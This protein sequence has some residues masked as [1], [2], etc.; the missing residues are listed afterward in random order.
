MIRSKNAGKLLR[1][2]VVGVGRG[3]SFARGM[4][5]KIGMKLVALCDTWKERLK[6]VGR[7]Y[8]VATYASYEKFLEHEMDAVILANYFHQHAPF[9][10]QALRA[11]CHVMSETTAAKT[12][13][14]C[15]A[16]CREVE[17]SGRIYMFAENYPYMLAVQEMRRL[18]QAGEIG[19]VRYA[20][21]EYNH[22]ADEDWRLSISPGLRHWRNWLPPTYYCSHALAPLMFVTDTLPVRVNALSIIEE[23]VQ[24]PRTVRVADPG[25]PILVRMDNGSVFRIWGLMLS[26]IH[27]V[28]YE[29]HGERGLLTTGDPLPSGMLRIYH[30]NW[31]R[32]TGEKPHETLYRPDWPDHG[33]LASQA[34]HGGGDFWTSF[35]FVR[36]IRARRQPYLDCYRGVSMSAVGIQGWRS[37][38]EEGKPYPIPDFRNEYERRAFENDHWSPFPEDAGPGQPPP[39]ILGYV[40][41]DRKALERAGR[42]WKGMGY[43]GKDLPPV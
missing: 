29:V 24:S 9:A 15:V 1:V 20:E 28:R 42:V 32:K 33:N 23:A 34:G 40:S 19:A 36:A 37:C 21:G 13:A 18:Y 4:N 35:H 41:P 8:R 10:I 14:E 17:R 5:E 38:L 16:L 7:Q 11:G 12:M 6:T 39:S 3:Q 2:G 27:R 30:E 43:K 22:A 31:L 25:A 26:S